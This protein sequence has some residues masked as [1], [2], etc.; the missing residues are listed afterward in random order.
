MRISPSFP[1]LF[2]SPVFLGVGMLLDVGGNQGC[3]TQTIFN[4]FDAWLIIFSFPVQ[5][6][7]ASLENILYFWCLM[8]KLLFLL[9]RIFLMKLI[10]ITNSVK[11]CGLDFVSILCRKVC[12]N[13]LRMFN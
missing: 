11:A 7:K 10:L 1:L 5:L 6:V 13:I 8:V 2:L 4:D 9:Y 12:N 3:L